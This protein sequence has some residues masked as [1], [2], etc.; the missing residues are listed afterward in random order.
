VSVN[1]NVIRQGRARRSAVGRLAF[2]SVALM[3]AACTAAPPATPGV[4][5]A[6]S[7]ELSPDATPAAATAGATPTGAP[8][9]A[10]AV[11]RPFEGTTIRMNVVAGERNAEG[12][13]D[14]I[15]EIRERFGI[16]LQVTD[17][18]LGDLIAKNA[19]SGRSPRRCVRRSRSTRSCTCSASPSPPFLAPGC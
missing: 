17:Y 15:D 4:S 13:R 6:A 7:P 2:A 16:E 10:T 5:P 8:A 12:V 19:E 11:S 9:T 3:L 14:H 1:Y 18:A